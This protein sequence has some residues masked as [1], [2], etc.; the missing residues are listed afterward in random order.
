MQL[1]KVTLLDKRG[2]L[3]VCLFLLRFDSL[4]QTFN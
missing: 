3:T 4:A 2:Y 1:E